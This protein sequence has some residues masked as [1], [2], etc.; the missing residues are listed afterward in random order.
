LAHHFLL[1]FQERFFEFWVYVVRFVRLNQ[2]DVCQGCLFVRLLA[3]VTEVRFALTAAYVRIRSLNM[4]HSCLALLA[5]L[6]NLLLL[7][8]R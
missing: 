2:V 8:L 3:V 1:V 7:Q 4:L 5:I 6:R